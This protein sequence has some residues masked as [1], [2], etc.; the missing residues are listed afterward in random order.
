M[1]KKGNSYIGCA[2][3]ICGF[4]GLAAFFGPL[5]RYAWFLIIAAAAAVAY[6]INKKSAPHSP[7]PSQEQVTRQN[8]PDDRENAEKIVLRIAAQNQGLVTPMEIAIASDLSMDEASRIL[9]DMRKK[10]Y[11]S[12]RVAD[13]GSYVYEI[14]GLLSMQQKKDSERL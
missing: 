9:E 7:P 4:V 1:F 2:I 10:G 3:V 14:E 12:L 8:E 5:S 6:W 13:N 11:A